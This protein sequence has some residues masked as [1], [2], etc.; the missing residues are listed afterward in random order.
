MYTSFFGL[1]EKPFAITP[2]PRYL[3]MSERHG[4]GLAHLLYGVTDS[5]GFIQLTGEVGTG[6]T[7]LVRTLLGQLPTEVDVAL[8]LNPQ[9]TVLEFLQAI[10]R[11][12]DVA[13]SEDRNSPMALVDSLNRYL[14]DAHARG[15]RIIL[16]VDEAQNL[17]EE[18]L[19]Q[20]RLLTNLET[21][22]QK[23][24]QIILIGQPELREILARNNLRQLAQRVTGR[25]HLEPL[26][27]DEAAK[28]I[29]HR[30]R[31]AGAVGEIFDTG[32]KHEVHRIAGGIPRIMNVIC[33]RA[34]LGA[35]SQEQRTVDRQ[36]VS[37]AAA[38]VAGDTGVSATLSP[39]W[40]WAAG[41]AALAVAVSLGFGIANLQRPSEEPVTTLT[42]DDAISSDA[43]T[44]PADVDM[45]TELAIATL[46]ET[47]GSPLDEGDELPTPATTA[48]DSLMTALL[49]GELNSSTAAAMQNLAALWGFDFDSS[50]GAVCSR[51][52]AVG[53]S[54]LYQRGS[55]SMLRKLDRPAVLTL[56][57]GRGDNHYAV[58]AGLDEAGV[59]LRFGDTEATYPVSEVTELWYGQYMLIWRPPA[60]DPS[61]IRPGTRSPAVVWLRESLA[62]LNGEQTANSDAS[63]FFDADLEA[64]L[65]QFQRQQRLQVDVLAGEQTQIIINSVLSPDATP[66]LS[67]AS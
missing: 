25:Y 23:L 63:D 26:S 17:S 36:L 10:C 67:G 20:L 40:K 38:E 30:M 16:L 61:A 35:F 32:A 11:E 7:T 48:S 64:R 3:F 29:E 27:R 33:D 66:T 34:L 54:C 52:T 60:G 13:L 18:V 57:D 22:K 51:A 49:S 1:N 59:T 46:P 8:I 14:L 62:Q 37:G 53:L 24:L 41:V 43:S 5:G 15:R 6:K 19:E 58:L 45:P 28:Y 65:R 50:S 56:T 4:E 44:A 31:V 42:P 55:L 12:L 9:V 21:A 47:A 39:A 2:D